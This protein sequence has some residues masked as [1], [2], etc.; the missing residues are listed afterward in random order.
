[1]GMNKKIGAL[2]SAV[3]MAG[4]W[5]GSGCSPSDEAKDAPAPVLPQASPEASAPRTLTCS[6]LWTSRT[7]W[8]D[9][10]YPWVEEFRYAHPNVDV[11]I[12][13]ENT[14]WNLEADKIVGMIQT[15]D[16]TTDV[17]R[18]NTYVYRIVSN[19]LNDPEWGKKHLHD[20]LN[21]PDFVQLHRPKL[22]EWTQ[23]RGRCGGIWPG[24]YL[25]TKYACVWYNQA[26]GNRMGIRPDALQL[27]RDDLLDAARKL[28]VY[29]QTAEQ[30]VGLFGL[31]DSGR[32]AYRLLR[33]LFVSALVD[34]AGNL[35]P[36][37]AAVLRK[38]ALRSALVFMEQLSAYDVFSRA[39]KTQDDLG[40]FVREKTLFFPAYT[41]RYFEMEAANGP[42]WMEHA[43]LLESPML[44]P[45]NFAFGEFEHTWAVMENSP[46]CALGVEFLKHIAKAQSVSEAVE[47]S[48]L[49][50]GLRSSFFATRKKNRP[51]DTYINYMIKQYQDNVYEAYVEALKFWP[52]T[53][54]AFQKNVFL[55]NELNGILLRQNSAEEILEKI[56][57]ESPSSTL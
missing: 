1:M 28:H 48:L 29:N 34:G 10:L 32:S 47:G 51:L 18:M 16:F 17:V 46:D 49:Q 31:C 4:L 27:S 44:K 52:E 42:E 9:S 43:L 15:G 3:W 14:D 8:I 57:P 6:G 38:E 11:V 13:P 19:R 50:S 41:D 37:D 36:E 24:P 7:W 20:F 56:L 55:R 2:I 5:L 30:K 39:E 23:N 26:L 33:R 35:P 12:H 40:L 25:E 53:K 21:E 22:V 45:T 54:P